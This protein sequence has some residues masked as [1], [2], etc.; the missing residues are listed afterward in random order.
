[1]VNVIFGQ[2]LEPDCLRKE[3]NYIQYKNPSVLKTFNEKWNAK[4]KLTVLHLGDGIGA[5]G[6]IHIGNGAGSNN[7][8]NI[9]N[10]N[11]INHPV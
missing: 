9:L 8:I 6:G 7:N 2:I 3:Y 4:K 11:S 5:S 1:M 10:G